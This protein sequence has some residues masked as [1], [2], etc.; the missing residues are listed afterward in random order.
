MKTS[1]IRIVIGLIIFSIGYFVWD[2]T[3]GLSMQL[4]CYVGMLVGLICLLIEE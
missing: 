1:I 4:A 3:V 2:P